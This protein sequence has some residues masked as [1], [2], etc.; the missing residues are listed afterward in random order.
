MNKINI[1]FFTSVLLLYPRFL[2]SE[3]II[4]DT[5]YIRVNEAGYLPQDTKLA[6]AFS[7]D[8]VPSTFKVVDINTKSVVYTGKVSLT[9]KTGWAPFRYFY[10]LDFSTL[11]KQ[12]DYMITLNNGKISSQHFRIGESVYKGYADELLEFMRQQRCGYNPFFDQVCHQKDARMMYGPMPDS[13]YVDV[14][15]GWHDA[16]DQLKYL[17][18]GSFATAIMMEAYE[19]SPSVFKDSVNALGQ[20]GPNGIPDVLDEAKWGLD[21]IQ[22]M[23]PRPDWLFHQV[24]DDRDHMGWKL[25]YKEISDYGWGKGSYRVVY[26]ATGKPQGLKQ[27]KSKATGIANIAGR[28]SA[29]MALGYRIWKNDL[30]DTVFAVQCLKSAIELYNMGKNQEGYQQGNS[31]GAPYRYNEE[32]WADD[33]EWAAAELYAATSEK[34]YLTDAIHYAGLIEATSWMQYDSVA[35][36][37]YYPFVNIGH[38]ALYHFVD[39]TTKENL[40]AYYRSGIEKCLARGS[41]NMYDEGAPFIWCSNNLEVAL[42][43]Q[44]ILYEKMTGDRQFH[45]FLLAQR[46]WLLGNNPWGTSMFMNIPSYG[47]YPKEVHTSTWALTKTEVPGGLVDGPVFASIYKSLLGI[48]LSHDDPF[49][50]F[51]NNYVVYHDDVG[52]YSTNEPTMDGTASAVLLMAWFGNIK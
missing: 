12:G 34:K 21:W 11:R 1:F 37:Q 46:D 9:D 44:I 35:H 5:V 38:Y 47:E 43:T 36:Y 19:L 6:V 24:G 25:P 15:G 18:T 32:T 2:F 29:A 51:Q 52:D 10:N 26:F 23:H 22:K 50:P 16:G 3:N 13:T 4:T 42:A 7:N 17:I 33:M 31:Y 45:K 8:P 49:A 28:S 27:Y 48:H 30:K 20:A 39:N 40:A 14:T 41:K